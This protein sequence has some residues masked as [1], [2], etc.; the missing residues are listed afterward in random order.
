MKLNDYFDKIY[1]INLDRRTDRWEKCKAEFDKF[2]IEVERFSALDGNTLTYNNQRLKSGEVGLIRSNLELIKKAKEN[3]YKNILIFEDDVEFTNNFNEKFEK[4]IKQVPEDWSFLYL[5]GNHVGGTVPINRNLHRVIHSYTTHA[6]AINAKIYDV[7]IDVLQKETEP[8]DVTYALLQKNNPSYVFRPHLAWQAEG[9]SDIV[10]EN[11][12]YN[13]LKEEKNFITTN[14]MGGLGNVLFKLSAAISLAK[15]N[16][17]DYIFSNEFLRPGVDNIQKNYTNILKKITFLPK[18]TTSYVVH[19]EPSFSYSPIK[20]TKGTN[21]LIE[22]YYQSEK[23]FINNKELII[24]LFGP[25]EEYKNDI[26]KEIPDVSNSISIHV[27][28]GD[29]LL[30]PNQHPLQSLEYYKTAIN[31]FGVDKKYIIFSDDIE[32]VKEMFDFLP[33]KV[34]YNSGKDWHDLYV[35]SMCEHNIIC[36]SSFSWWGAYLNNNKN[37]V[38]FAPKK[39]FGPAYSNIDASDLIPSTWKILDL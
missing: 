24:N 3:K 38:I 20:Y 35:M 34:F 19:K 22:G 21:L 30:Y 5:G 37:K 9:F 12:N 16:D 27:R 26:V 28:R 32:D 29:Y 2:G 14:H 1:C 11:V 15:D 25:S 18:L 4:Y 13:F 6:F 31:Y 7:I 33:N 39:W 17:L 36:N 23:Y 10:K 8:V